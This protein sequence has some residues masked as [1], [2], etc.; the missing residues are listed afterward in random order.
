MMDMRQSHPCAQW[1]RSA[2]AVTR[3]NLQQARRSK[4]EVGRTLFLNGLFSFCFLFPPI[5]LG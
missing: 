4:M 5:T 3:D 1:V 2:L